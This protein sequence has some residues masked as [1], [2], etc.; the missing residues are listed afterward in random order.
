MEKD[1]SPLRKHLESA[2][3]SGRFRI[4]RLH[5]KCPRPV[6]YLWQWFLQL[7]NHRQRTESGPC[8]ISHSELRAWAM[9]RAVDVKPR[10]VELIMLLDRAFLEMRSA[11]G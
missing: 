4:D 5:R 3:R 2:E 7:H 9:L 11:N 1:G 6:E 8:P 10:E